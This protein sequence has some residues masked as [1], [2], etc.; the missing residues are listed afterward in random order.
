MAANENADLLLSIIPHRYLNNVVFISSLVIVGGGGGGGGGG[1]RRRP[2]PRAMAS[3]SD[4]E[5][6]AKLMRCLIL[7]H[8]WYLALSHSFSLADF[9]RL[10]SMPSVPIIIILCSSF[11]P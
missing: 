5:E 11:A 9:H 7:S 4:V 3:E 2:R 10:V 1:R 8:I 6:G